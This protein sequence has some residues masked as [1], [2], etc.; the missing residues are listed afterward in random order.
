MF[1]FEREL[2]SMSGGGAER[3]RERENPKQAP[4]CQH[5]AWCRAQS[6]EPW[7][8]DLSQNQELT[9]NWLSHPGTPKW[10]I[11]TWGDH[12]ELFKWSLNVITRIL[13]R[14]RQRGIWAMKKAMWG[15]KQNATMLA[16]KLEEVGTN[17]ECKNCIS[18]SWKRGGD[19]LP[20]TASGESM[21]LSKPR[22]C[23]VKPVSLEASRSMR[24]QMRWACGHLLQE[25][26]ET[27]IA[28]YI[29]DKFYLLSLF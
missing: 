20:A 15:L 18:R 23:S 9:L 5:R 24:E 26:Q 6:Q 14:G 27:N 21:T 28:I 11:L 13:M 29:P 4:H 16:W 1:I 2:A 19:R 7:E 8:H 22:C 10:K 17:K 25:P 12:R 3:E